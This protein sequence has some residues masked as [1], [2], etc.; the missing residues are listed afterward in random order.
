MSRYVL[1]RIFFLI[2]MLINESYADMTR[3]DIA[4]LSRQGVQVIFPNE[5]ARHPFPEDIDPEQLLTAEMLDFSNIPLGNNTDFFQWLAKFTQLRKLVLH[6]TQIHASAELIHAFTGMEDLQKLDLSN[7]PLFAEPFNTAKLDA[8]WG[9]LPKLNEL[10]LTAT[11]GTVENY[12]SLSLLQNLATLLLG[13]NPK[14]CVRSL[15]GRITS[16][17]DG[18]CIKSLELGKLPLSVL[19]LSNTNLLDDPLPDLPVATLRELSLEKNGLETL[20]VRDL[21][22]LEYW[23]LVGNPDLKLESEFGNILNLKALQ[24]LRYD[25]SATIPITLRQRLAKLGKQQDSPAPERPTASSS[26]ILPAPSTTLSQPLLHPQTADEIQTWLTGAD[27][28]K[29]QAALDYLH[30]EANKGGKYAKHW[31][32]QLYHKGWGVK[33]DWSKARTYYQ[34]AEKA[35]D[36]QAHDSLNALDHEA[37]NAITEWGNQGKN[38]TKSQLAF[39]LYTALAQEGNKNAKGW[40]NWLKTKQ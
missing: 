9:K 26:I 2:T 6:N 25:P 12:S 3:D 38:T 5:T 31:L 16:W 10:N 40:L 24:S 34:A 23:N 32:G 27:Q 30:T 13:D 8:L 36:T 7:N 18:A 39:D 4:V 11:D 22:Q 14:L 35:G 17:A 29:Q 15:L 1:L 20:A 33:M 19:D 28:I 37:A 21:P